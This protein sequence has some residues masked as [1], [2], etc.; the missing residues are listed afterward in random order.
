[1]P[2]TKQRTWQGAF[3]LIGILIVAE[4]AIISVVTSKDKPVAPPIPPTVSKAQLSEDA[5][6]RQTLAVT[7]QDPDGTVVAL[8]VRWADGR[9]QRVEY[10]CAKNDYGGQTSQRTITHDD[11]GGTAPVQVRAFGRS[12]FPGVALHSGPW[13]NATKGA[14]APDLADAPQ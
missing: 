12:C 4:L 8:E 14:A 6:G 1:M 7:A 11:A 3:V 10:A 13:V 2:A 5:K 9:T